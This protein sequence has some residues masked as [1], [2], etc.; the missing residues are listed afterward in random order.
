ML[1]RFHEAR[2]EARSLA[3]QPDGTSVT[4]VFC[5]WLGEPCDGCGHTF[6]EGDRV[7]ADRDADGGRTTIRHLDPLLGCAGGA[8]AEVEAG[9]MTTRFHDA[10]DKA[11]PP[12]RRVKRLLPGD[13][14]LRF[15]QERPYCSCCSYTFRPFEVVVRCPCGE[16]D[17]DVAFHRDPQRG[18][19]CFDETWPDLKVTYCP[20]RKRAMR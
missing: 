16:L 5:D 17:C 8:I 20:F 4:T 15:H 13:S 9:E 10:V 6:R 19:L 3:I 11:V 2:D 1:R 12:P 7:R 18:L 14:L